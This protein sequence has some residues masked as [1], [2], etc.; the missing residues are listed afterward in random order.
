TKLLPFS[1]LYEPGYIAFHQDDHRAHFEEACIQL[2]L[3][4]GDAI[5]FNPALFH[6]AGEN[7]SADIERMANLLPVSSAFGRAM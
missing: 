7:R 2:P 4:K 5:F 6:G 3:E 1:Q